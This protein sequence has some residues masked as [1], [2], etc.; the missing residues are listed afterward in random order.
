[1]RRS[2]DRTGLHCPLGETVNELRDLALAAGLQPDWYDA[3]GRQMQVS[4]ASLSAVLAALGFPAESSAEITE[5]RTALAQLRQRGRE[6]FVSSDQGEQ[7][8]LPPEFNGPATLEF[9]DGRSQD[10]RITQGILPP[11]GETGYHR[12]RH[13]GGE[14]TIA[15]APPRCFALNDLNSRARVWGAAAQLPS[16]RGTEPAPFGD[17]GILTQTIREL[18][19]VG[20]DLLAI[21]P[22]HALFPADPARF[23]PYG[24]S[25]RRLLNPLFIDPALAGIKP[26]GGGQSE[27]IDWE[28]EAPRRFADLRSAFAKLS[29][30]QRQALVPSESSDY[31]DLHRHGVYDALDAYFR[32]QGRYGWQAWPEAIHDPRSESVRNFAADHAEDVAFHVWL[33]MLADSSLASAQEASRDAGMACGIITDLAVGVDPGGSDTWNRPDAYMRGLSVGAPPDLLGPDGQDW[34]LT[35]FNP[36][37]MPLDDFNAFRETL[38]AAM[39]SA[40][41]VRIDHFLGMRRI[42]AVPRGRP[43]SEGCYISFP[44]QDLFRILAIE[45]WRHRAIVIGED[46]GTVPEG[47]R[48]EMARTAIAG[49]RVLWFERGQDGAYSDPGRW[50][51]GAAAMTSTHDLPTLAGWWTGRDIDWTWSIGRKSRFDREDDERE[52]RD[53]ERSRIWN[54]LTES[55]HADGPC[56]PA[57]SSD[58][59]VTAACVHVA[60]SACDLAIIPLEDL[61]GLTEQPNL[62]GTTA[63]HP[64]WRRRLPDSVAGLLKQPQIA[65]RASRITKE[66]QI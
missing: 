23:S 26:E 5:S 4:D 35:T 42:W 56:P 6:R 60:A 39:K 65:G 37:T 11:I 57:S 38:A 13:S 8:I 32:R 29:D 64:N 43:S 52:D 46:L 55:G 16:L 50:D 61:L 27:L 40:G 20:A 49:M 44:Q 7:I 21:S 14:T 25:S 36:L 62:P 53:K 19:G 30:A 31:E 22:V 2:M 1:M 58:S 24:P 3:A 63:E 54:A 47:L 28:G 10:V 59:F 66:R 17:F 15:I 33:Q 41:G 51:E 12:L 48:E 9:E 18:A 45:S 34:G